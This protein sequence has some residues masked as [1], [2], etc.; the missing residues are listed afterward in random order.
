VINVISEIQHSKNLTRLTTCSSQQL[1]LWLLSPFGEHV[2]LGHRQSIF[3]YLD[4]LLAEFCIEIS[5][6]IFTVAQDGIAALSS[7]MNK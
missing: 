3:N 7:L 6:R 2:D 1:S 4:A 5:V